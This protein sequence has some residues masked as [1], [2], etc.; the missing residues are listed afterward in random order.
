MEANQEMKRK[1]D[2]QEKTRWKKK[3][4]VG[5]LAGAS[6]LRKEWSELGHLNRTRMLDS[7]INV[8]TLAIASNLQPKM[9]ESN[10]HQLFLPCI[11]V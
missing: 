4:V 3:R 9:H 2:I 10:R 11:Q 1:D 5:T 6:M 7:E 8:S